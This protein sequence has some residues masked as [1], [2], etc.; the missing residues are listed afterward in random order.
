VSICIYLSFQREHV[1]VK[2]GSGASPEYEIRF[3][4]VRNSLDESANDRDV[5]SGRRFKVRRRRFAAQ[6][7]TQLFIRRK[8][9][10]MQSTS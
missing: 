9:W 4:Q 8:Q 3:A 6:R 7:Q 2:T 5:L 1:P 10:Q